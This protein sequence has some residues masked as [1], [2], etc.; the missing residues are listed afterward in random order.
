M[1]SQII[2]DTE[3]LVAKAVEQ[4]GS[5]ALAEFYTDK[6][7]S[8]LE[9]PRDYWTHI[10]HS[11]R[12][13]FAWD[14]HFEGLARYLS[15]EEMEI[16]DEIRELVYAKIGLDMQYAKRSMLKR[17]LFVHIPVSYALVFFVL[18][19]TLLVYGFSGS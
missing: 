18:L 8:F 14:K 12:V 17:W 13:R 15:P 19:H 3:A 16:A 7:L 10:Y 1:R 2:Q 6:L 11:Q 9:R 4:S 5:R